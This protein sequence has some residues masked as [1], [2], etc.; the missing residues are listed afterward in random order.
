MTDGLE[1]YH[2]LAREQEGLINANC[3]AHA[4]RHFANAIKA[5]GKGNQEAVK[6]SVAYK[7]LVRIGAI[8]DLEGALKTLSSDERL[9]ERQT[10]I[11]P[12]VEEYFAWVKEVLTDGTVLPKS[13][14]AKGLNYS[15][16]QEEYLKVFLTDGEVP[17][18]DSA[19]ERA[20]RNFTIGRK[21]WMTINTVRGAQASAV[22]YSITETAR[23]NDLNVYYYIKYLL[24]E[25]P[26]LV[27]E[28]GNIEQSMLGPLML[29]LK[30]V[31]ADCYSKR[32]S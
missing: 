32:R 2:K 15:I 4:R 20:L 25:L 11:K 17:I 16:N 29:W 12:L 8:Y 6:S 5:M 22:I 31:P 13:E 3:F 21:N 18:D 19:S 23:A 28:N 1:Q 24:T 27:D 7:A 26:R 9:K 14:T 10:S 30:T